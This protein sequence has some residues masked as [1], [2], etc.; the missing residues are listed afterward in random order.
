MDFSGYQ[1]NQMLDAL[2]LC[3]QFLPVVSKPIN[4]NLTRF[5][6]PGKRYSEFQVDSNSCPEAQVISFPDLLF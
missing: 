4:N 6:P 5:V 1:I 2:V 3:F